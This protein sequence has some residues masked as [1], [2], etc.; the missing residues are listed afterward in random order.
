MWFLKQYEELYELEQQI[1]KFNL[2]TIDSAM[3]LE[4]KQKGFAD[5]QVAL[6]C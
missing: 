2:S 3:L 1:S 4:A 6:I 5:R